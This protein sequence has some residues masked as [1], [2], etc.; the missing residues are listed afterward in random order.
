MA[1]RYDDEGRVYFSSDRFYMVDTRYY[2]STREGE[3]VGP[4][5]TKE[6]AI[7]ALD[8]YIDCV[9][10]GVGSTTK[11]RKLAIQGAWATTNFR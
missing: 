4:F 5:E 6:D 11:A 3:E 1:K 7:A 10:S 2:F 8:H 9:L